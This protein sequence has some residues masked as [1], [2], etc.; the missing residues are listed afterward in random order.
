MEVKEY[1]KAGFFL[2]LARAWRRQQGS[3]P[4]VGI[5]LAGLDQGEEEV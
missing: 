5:P 2:R 3:W 1:G 4:V